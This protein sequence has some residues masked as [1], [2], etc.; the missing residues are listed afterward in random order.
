[1]TPSSA[2]LIASSVSGELLYIALI[3]TGAVRRIGGPPPQAH[4]SSILSLL[5]FL[6]YL[7]FSFSIISFYFFFAF[8]KFQT[9]FKT[10]NL[11]KSFNFFFKT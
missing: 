11:K 1:V 6:V 3:N 9:F 10:E 7:I 4:P 8:F 5:I 2:I